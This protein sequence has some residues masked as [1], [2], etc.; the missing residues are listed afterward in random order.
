MAVLDINNL[1][2]SFKTHKADVHAVR[3]VSLHIDKGE[4]LALVGE[5]GSGKSTV[6]MSVLQLLPYPTA[7]HPE[8]SS[9]KFEGKELMGL[10]D[11]QLRSIRGDRISMIFQEPMT[12]LNP[13]HNIYKQISE[14]LFLHQPGITKKDAV[15]QVKTLLDEVGLS[16]MK[17]R[18][19]S[20]PHQLSGGERQRIMIAMAMA[21][22]PDLLI[23]DEPTTA[24]DVTVQ[25]QI[26]RLLKDLQ[27]KRKMAI[28]LITHDLTIV[29]HVAD[30]VYVM[31]E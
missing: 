17:D 26:L 25:A 1:S 21:N 18:L 5:S 12:A 23:A 30:R 29:R 7:Y 9:V 13:L 31:T 19:N 27:K 24:L 14:T 11:R 16:H 8:G 6:A 28:L 10:P 2:V 15:E 22:K 3:D 4:I 20:L